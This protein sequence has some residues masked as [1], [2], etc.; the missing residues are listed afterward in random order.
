MGLLAFGRAGYREVPEA[1]RGQQGAW[2]EN[3]TWFDDGQ[4]GKGGKQAVDEQIDQYYHEE[5][6]EKLMRVRG[7]S[8][9]TRNVAY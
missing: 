3:E 8:Y 6:V 7:V 5:L 9:F 2:G 4:H 1:Y